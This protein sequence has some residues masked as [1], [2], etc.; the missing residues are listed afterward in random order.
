MHRYTSWLVAIFFLLIS[1]EGPNG[2]T[3]SVEKPPIPLSLL[4][5]ATASSSPEADPDLWLLAHIDV[6]TTGLLPG[7]HEMIDIGLVY[8]NLSGEILDS[9]F[10]RIHANHPDRCSA[11]AKQINSYDPARWDSL[12]ALTTRAAVDSI[13]HFH[14]QTAVNRPTLM[15]SFNSHFDLSFLDQLF[16]EEGHSWREMFHYFV[17]DIPSMAWSQGYR[18]LYLARFREERGIADESHVAEEH[19]GISG[20]MKNVRIYKELVKGAGK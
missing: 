18:D 14:M 12:K 16:R 4:A 8:T 11:I 20:A 7:Y 5:S 2:E 15:V 3:N 10:L 13:L 19:T 17:L 9:L 1:C 6:E